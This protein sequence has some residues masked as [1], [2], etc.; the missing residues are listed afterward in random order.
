LDKVTNVVTYAEK[1]I[2]VD[3]NI[4]IQI[5]ESNIVSSEGTLSDEE[6][7]IG[8]MEITKNSDEKMQRLLRLFKKSKKLRKEMKK[9]TTAVEKQIKQLRRVLGIR[10]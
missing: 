4:S 7:D 10:F 2:I 1:S 9:K 5:I 6:L 3:A 8:E